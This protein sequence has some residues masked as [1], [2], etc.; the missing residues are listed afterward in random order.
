MKKIF[1]VV[2]VMLA[3]IA[4]Q[5]Q[6]IKFGL[7]AG[8]NFA[9]INGDY[10][11]DAITSFH[12]GAVLELNLTDSFSVQGEALFSSQGAKFEDA[13]DVNL[14]YFAVPVM[15]KFYILPDRLSIEAGPQFSFLTNDV[16]ENGVKANSFD[17]AAVGGAELRIIGGLFAQ[18]RYTAGLMDIYDNVKSK[19]MVFQLSVGYMF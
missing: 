11:A 5:A 1:L 17:T 3:G 10:N 14:N 19:N 8:A 6:G 18:A 2:T 16:K 15:A 4:M 12:G 9:N 13:D 7:K